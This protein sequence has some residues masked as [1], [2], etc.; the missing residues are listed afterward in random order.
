MFAA[1]RKKQIES[2]KV[3]N[4]TVQ[5]TA[6][7]VYRLQIQTQFG[8][9]PLEIRF[10]PQFPQIAP[11]I[12]LILS[13]PVVHQWVDQN[14]NV[15]R[16]PTLVRW[17]VHTDV[18]ALVKQIHDEFSRNPP[19]PQT[20]P[21]QQ[22]QQV[23]HQPVPALQNPRVAH[24]AVPAPTP[25]RG[26]IGQ[27]VI[28]QPVM[29]QPVPGQPG[30]RQPKVLPGRSPV[31]QPSNNQFHV[32]NVPLPSLAELEN[33]SY[34]ELLVF[35]SEKKL[36]EDFIENLPP[37]KAM[38][39]TISG[40]YGE[41][42]KMARKNLSRESEIKEKQAELKALREQV[43]LKKD[44][45]EPYGQKKGAIL[46]KF[47]FQN[48]MKALNDTIE[49]SEEKGD[50]IRVRYENIDESESDSNSDDEKEVDEITHS[51]FCKIYTK[52]RKKTHI[53]LAKKERLETLYG[54]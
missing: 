26:N 11:N 1:Q 30:F 50:K 19:K 27:P 9:L 53:L 51:R 8:P 23:A 43:E 15:S 18:G 7:D 22:V 46:Q 33:K 44:E 40:L 36:R 37:S 17:S 29:G 5:M 49:V 13:S 35:L 48:I 6:A 2:L 45:Y 32:K 12:R 39:E 25:Y 54:Q 31:A 16:H 14:L 38:E 42:E 3:R 24:R 20:N 4:P 41:I 52:E 21:Q 10:A 28:G 34:S 47:T